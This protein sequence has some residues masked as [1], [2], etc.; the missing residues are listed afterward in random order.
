MGN[1]KTPFFLGKALQADLGAISKLKNTACVYKVNLTDHNGN[2]I[3]IDWQ[4]V[5]I[6]HASSDIS[7]FLSRLSADGIEISK[8]KAIPITLEQ[9]QIL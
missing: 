8:E 7:F 9:R 6:G 1:I 4:N 3:V 5:S 2:I